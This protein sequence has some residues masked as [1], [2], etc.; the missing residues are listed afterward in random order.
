MHAMTNG[1]VRKI[2]VP[3]PSLQNNTADAERVLAA[4]EEAKHSPI[5]ATI[6]PDGI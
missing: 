2:S 4:L 1:W 3:A 6:I 5:A